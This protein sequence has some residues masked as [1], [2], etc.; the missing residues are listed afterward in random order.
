M[1]GTLSTTCMG[2]Q[3]SWWQIS[4]WMVFNMQF[5]PSG[6]PPTQRSAVGLSSCISRLVFGLSVD[7]SH[8]AGIQE[9][10]PE[11]HSSV[12]LGVFQKRSLWIAKDTPIGSGNARGFRH[13]ARN[14]GID[15]NLFITE[16]RNL[17]YSPCASCYLGIPWF[18]TYSQVLFLWYVTVWVSDS[19]LPLPIASRNPYLMKLAGV[20]FHCLLLGPGWHG[21]KRWS[22][23][24]KNGDIQSCLHVSLGVM[25]LQ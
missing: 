23:R 17:W 8:T 21:V 11:L 7:Q 1:V 15:A 12:E 13:S 18:P 10:C 22:K 4:C 25:G 16:Q 2:C 3:C 5:L 20:G 14:L 6:P 9:P 24:K 19:T